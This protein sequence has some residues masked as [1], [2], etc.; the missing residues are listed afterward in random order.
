MKCNK[1]L[2]PVLAML[3]L[4]PMLL[5]SASAEE[6]LG[7][8]AIPSAATVD[9]GETVE[10]TLSLTG[11]TAEVS[12]GDAIR[13]LQ[14]DITNVTA[15]LLEV[16]EY[17]SLIPEES[18]LSN[19]AS[20][21]RDKG[22]VRLLYANMD[23]T[24]PGPCD[25]VLKVVFRA[26]TKLGELGSIALPITVKIQTEA[27]QITLTDSLVITCREASGIRIEPGELHQLVAGKNQ[28]LTAYDTTT[29]KKVTASWYLEEGDGDYA[30]L[31]SSGSL[32]AKTVT[33]AQTITVYARTSSG[34]EAS[35]TI[36][37][38]PKAANVTLFREGDALDHAFAVDLS[39]MDTL[40]LT[41]SVAPGDALQQVT[42]ASS[43]RGVATVDEEGLVTL[44]KP[45]T[46]TIT[47]AAADGSKAS[48]KVK[49]TAYYVDT[50]G[51][52]TLTSDAPSIGLQPGQSAA[53]T[54]TGTKTLD[55]ALL[56]FTSSDPDVARVENG[57]VI[58]GDKP[59]N[60]TITASLTGDPLNRKATLK[61]KV[62]T[63]QTAE[64]I[65]T[66][67]VA[68]EN[69]GDHNGQ[70]LVILDA[71]AV[72]SGSETFRVSAQA[73]DYAGTECAAGI[74]WA[75]S[76][77]AIATVRD[78]GDGYATVT[79]KKGASGDCAITATSKDLAKVTSHLWLSVRDYQPRIGQT[80]LNLELCKS[81]SL[82]L[83]LEESYNNAITGYA[84]YEGDALSRHFAADYN[85][86]TLTLTALKDTARGTYTETLKVTCGN[87]AEYTYT[88]KIRVTETAP[89]VT[90]K[91]TGKPN[92]FY[93]ETSAT[94]A[95]SA[96]AAPVTGVAVVDGDFT[97]S[98]EDGVLTLRSDGGNPDEKVTLAIRLEGYARPVE[99]TI[100]L[101]TVTTAPKL[102]LSAAS[103][104]INTTSKDRSTRFQV[105]NGS[106]VLPLEED[107]ITCTGSFAGWS[108]SADEIT[109]TLTGTE[110]GTATLQIQ[111]EGWTK[112]V[113]L[114]HKVTVQ[115]ANPTLKLSAT[116]LQL[117]RIFPEREAS[118]GV[119]LSQ[120][121]QTLEAL[122]ITPKSSGAEKLNVIWNGA[123]GIT[124]R[125][126]DG[127]VEAG[128]YT[129][130][131]V[132][133]LKNGEPVK[134]V[135][136][137]IRV[138]DTSP[139]VKLKATTFKLNRY[140]AGEETIST[141]A[142]I[143]KGYQLVGFAGNGDLPLSYED[144]KL[145]VWL[146]SSADMGGSHTIYP[147]VIPDG[148]EEQVTLPKGITVK[149]NSYNSS[150]LSATVSA[151]GKLDTLKPDSAVIYT[152][153]L[154][155]CA[156]P[157][158]DARLSGQHGDLFEAEVLEGKV[159]IKLA[160]GQ[161]YATNKTY[162]VTLNLTACG[163][164]LPGSDLGIRVSQSTLKVK[165]DSTSVICYQALGK[166]EVC[167]AVTS[168][169]GAEID[170]VTLSTRTPAVFRSA[171]GNH[172]VHFDQVTGK[173]TLSL[174]NP[175]LLTPGRSYT[176]YLEVTPKNKATNA[177]PTQL[178]LTVKVQS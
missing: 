81:A 132:G 6:A 166:V 151:K 156:G 21:Q 24:L 159:Y 117:N 78:S 122:V 136:L 90:V 57:V 82:E 97:A 38:L 2:L 127:T 77:T 137:K 69:R 129:Y 62:I 91:Q 168:P 111:K 13:G 109:L 63:L 32:T 28:Q 26:K 29:N 130:T 7:F 47:A 139:T 112:P 143:S 115:T 160:A 48:A 101:A 119:S 133:K 135:T 68:E 121:N 155:N 25:Q 66:P 27:R 64:L 169:A 41:A 118:A 102:R 74:T 149:I 116:T 100:T 35:K 144:G 5:L 76:N 79:V 45:G 163:K 61:L 173:L 93:R 177:K 165:A 71:G 158:S 105:L 103:S 96:K 147:I 39:S 43:S 146:E 153:K 73:L 42:W 53:L 10:V 124:A 84:L 94:L 167:L 55:N 65:L 12:A 104:I 126:L 106:E 108:L 150:A 152:V 75:S 51:K 125:I 72:S 98:F 9:V 141:D 37:I 8:A 178:K 14:V 49:L 138:S 164:T 70:P 59:G 120:A 40:Q 20:F 60:V 148:C 58:S 88:L 89:A 44:L 113:K 52:L 85:A 67:Q 50:A 11:Y 16:V 128:T 34:A 145:T 4:L 3:L 31:S 176:I 19:T 170:Q 161:K 56:E 175:G 123:D 92:L 107:D 95:I 22:L 46:T 142:T 134:A 140:L 30:S 83:A 131:C 86:G 110:G 171:V 1:L 36:Q 33:Q 23:G 80:S 17:C 99:K 162:K 15:D 54:V 154:K 18:V 157:V 114:T 172:Q 87:G 174:E